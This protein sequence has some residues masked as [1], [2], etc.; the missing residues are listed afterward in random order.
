MIHCCH[1][2]TFPLLDV[3]WIAHIFS[4]HSLGG[5]WIP[6]FST[7]IFA[8]RMMSGYP[9]LLRISIIGKRI[10]ALEVRYEFQGQR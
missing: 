8:V 2:V 6:L 7:S 3:T 9:F 4:C 10:L 5:V 1:V